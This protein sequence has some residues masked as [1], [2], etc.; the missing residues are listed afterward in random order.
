LRFKLR[1]IIIAPLK[2]SEV[3]DSAELFGF[4]T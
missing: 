1:L 3:W 2:I 4:L